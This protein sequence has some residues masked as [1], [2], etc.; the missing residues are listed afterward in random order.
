MNP[1]KHNFVFE[2]QH[3]P[4]LTDT[5]SDEIQRVWAAVDTSSK[6]TIIGFLLA[7]WRALMTAH[8]RALLSGSSVKTITS[9]CDSST[10]EC[11]VIS[12]LQSADRKPMIVALLEVSTAA[13]TL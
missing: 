6:A 10:R 11:A 8:S 4:A 9:T 7:D 12:A 3:W 2:G 13:H 1:L 5:G